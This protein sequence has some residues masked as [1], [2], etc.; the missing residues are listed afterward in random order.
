[1]MS[2]HDSIRRPI[3]TNSSDA[4]FHWAAN[5]VRAFFLRKPKRRTPVNYGQL[6]PPRG[7]NQWDGG[8][9]T[10]TNRR[11]CSPAPADGAAKTPASLPSGSPSPIPGPR[12]SATR[13]RC[14]P[15]AAAGRPAGTFPGRRPISVRPG[16]LKMPENGTVLRRPR[17][18][19]G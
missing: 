14:A 2:V 11:R 16:R 9:T 13:I 15:D 1:M 6:P 4:G 3:C 17:T 8:G 7:A 5:S 19:A 12:R 18:P 10:L